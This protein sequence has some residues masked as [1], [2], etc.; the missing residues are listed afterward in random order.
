MKTS[1]YSCPQLDRKRHFLVQV[2]NSC[3]K[4]F[5]P[6]ARW[7]AAVPEWKTIVVPF[8]DSLITENDYRSRYCRQLEL[9]K[10]ALS[11][12]LAFIQREARGREVVLLCYETPR[13]FC[14]RHILASWLVENEFE[15]EIQE[16]GRT[17]ELFQ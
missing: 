3:P 14:H 17:P 8:K 11:R 4:G 15:N 12:S 5:T 16:L 9:R 2:S 6:D 1:Y 13:A 7:D 10:D